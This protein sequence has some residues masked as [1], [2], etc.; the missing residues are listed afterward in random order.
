MPMQYDKKSYRLTD[1]GNY[2]NIA[3]I[4]GIVGLIGSA[5]GYI[6][7]PKQFFHSYLTAY[8]FWLSLGLGGLFFVMLHH[9]VGAKWS[10][11]LRRLSENI[12]MTIPIMAI[13]FIP[14]LFG[15]KE[16]FHWSHPELVATDHLLQGKEPYLNTTFFIIRAVAYFV[17]WCALAF[18]LNRY[19]LAQ[20]KA[21]DDRLFRKLRVVSAPGMILFAR[22]ITFAGFDWLM[23]L[24]AHWYSTIFGVYVFSGGLLG[25]LAFLTFS[26]LSL[27]SKDVLTDVITPE[28]H[29]DLGKL[30]FA[31]TVFWA[32]MA[33]SQ[34]F[35]IWYG[36]IPEETVWFL[37]R[38]E[39]SWKIISLIIVFGHFGVPF[40]VLFPAGAKRH[41]GVLVGISLWL[42]LMHWVDLHWLV[43]PSLY[44]HGMHVSWMDPV[45]V[46]GLGGIFVWLFRR[47]TAAKPLVPV[48][49]PGLGDSIRFINH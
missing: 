4:V 30:L 21:H 29:H 28:H 44:P 3:L 40:F 36:N 18:L 9:L 45:T 24:D 14:L 16:L 38:W 6:S 31:F 32:Y 5:V 26:I 15:I 47:R 42:L 33:F 11:V 12:M 49:D 2:G 39:T 41:K 22:S 8:F 34:Y 23:S 13:L 43:M 37:E 1:A 7:D 35:L 20:D 17:I 25:M 48:N 19:S 10:I 27:R 46:I